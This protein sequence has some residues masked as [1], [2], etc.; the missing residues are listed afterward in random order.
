MTF[1]KHVPLSACLVGVSLLQGANPV[2]YLLQ[3]FTPV[4]VAP[5]SGSFRLRVTGTGFVYGAIV[6]WDG[7]PFGTTFVDSHNL[8]AAIPASKVAKPATIVITVSNPTP[9]GGMSNPQLFTVTNSEVRISQG[10]L[11]SPVQEF[12]EFLT[13][14]DFNRDGN[15][16]IMVT[17]GPSD[18]PN[19]GLLLGNGDGTFQPLITIPASPAISVFNLTNADFNRD[20][21]PDVA[22]TGGGGGYIQLGNGDG[23]FQSPLPVIPSAQGFALLAADVNEDGILDLLVSGAGGGTGLGVLLGN[24]DLTFQ[25]AV[26]YPAGSDVSGLVVTDLNNDGHLDVVT[27]DQST[28][29][30]T[31]LLGKGDGTFTTGQVLSPGCNPI[32]IVAGDFNGDGNQDIAAALYGGNT[33]VIYL[34]KGDGTF[35][36]PTTVTVPAEPS[37]V[38]AGDV[39]GDGILDLVTSNLT[40]DVSVLIGHGDGT[41]TLGPTTKT[42]GFPPVAVGLADFNSDGRLDIAALNYTFNASVFAILQ[43]TLQLNRLSVNFGSQKAGTSSPAQNV[44]VTNTGHSELAVATLTI[45]GTNSSDFFLV[46]NCGT[47]LAP[48]ASC[49]AQI[50]FKP[51]ATGT[52]TADLLVTDKSLNVTQTVSLTGTGI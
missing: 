16:D 22:V 14:A 15:P 48:G 17:D 36:T 21:I 6:N 50:S 12:P 26:V 2:P 11:S 47:S 45:T 29:R 43:S 24:A 13:I 27:S 39:N 1:F 9:E 3:S 19:L 38:A 5:G 8:T 20:G 23:T 51:A 18:F 7:A 33:V 42:A 41:F 49:S 35:G 37:A 40:G 46:T 30:I 52:N 25:P 34:G 28:C 10:V 32:S 4:S 31:V 44:T